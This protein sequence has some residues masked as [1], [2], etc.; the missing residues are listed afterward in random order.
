MSAKSVGI[1]ASLVAVYARKQ[2]LRAERVTLV[3]GFI[4]PTGA[5]VTDLDATV[6]VS[7]IVD[8]HYGA[9]TLLVLVPTATR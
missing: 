7:R 8:G 6:T 1:A 9:K 4:A 3:P 2:Q 5:K